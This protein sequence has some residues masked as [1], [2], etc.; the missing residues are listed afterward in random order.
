MEQEVGPQFLTRELQDC[1]M[2]FFYHFSWV[3]LMFSKSHELPVRTSQFYGQ[4]HA[5]QST[6]LQIV[7]SETAEVD[8]LLHHLAEVLHVQVLL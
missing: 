8:S 1:E 2:T 3:R 4:I 6:I 5:E 7:I